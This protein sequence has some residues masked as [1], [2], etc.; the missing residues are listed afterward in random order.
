MKPTRVLTNPTAET[1]MRSRRRN[2]ELALLLMAVVVILA[3][4]ILASLGRLA[5]IPANI[6]PFLIVI[7]GLLLV[8]HVATR[9]LAPQADP[10]LL[11]LA[12]LLNGFG[13]VFIARLDED[14]PVCRRRGRS[15]VSVRSSRLCSWCRGPVGSSSTDTH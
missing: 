7:L 13:Y 6:V 9:R 2:T 14:L 10:V 5:E 1:H 11:P 4:Y 3:A 8:A 15:S 12:G